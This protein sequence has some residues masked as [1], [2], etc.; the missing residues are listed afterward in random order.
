V[1]APDGGPGLPGVGWSTQH[2]DLRVPHFFGLHGLQIIPFVG[3]LAMRRR[4]IQTERQQSTFAF[5][6]AVSYLSLIGILTWQALR[7]QS[8]ID[9]DSLTLAALGIWFALSAVA[10]FSALSATLP[11]RASAAAR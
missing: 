5:T 6:I 3:W 11:A 7:G 1:G 9:P 10:I 4:R 8:I 2:G